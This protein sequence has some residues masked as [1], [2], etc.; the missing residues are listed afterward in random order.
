[1][2]LKVYDLET[3]VDPFYPVH[4]LDCIPDY[5]RHKPDQEKGLRRRE[6]L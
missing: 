5:L 4:L 6:D 1:M 3:V 2:R